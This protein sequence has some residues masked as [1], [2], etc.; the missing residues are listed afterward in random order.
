MPANLPRATLVGLSAILLWSTTIGLLRSVSEAF[1]PTGGAALIYSTTAVL[2]CLTRGVPN[3][4]NMPG[5]YLLTGGV[6]FVGYEICLA[7]AVGLARDRHQS[8]EMGMIN[9]LWPCLTI[10]LAIPFNQQ[11]FR[12][13]LWPG[14]LLS[15]SG[16]IWVM[17][18]ANGNVTGKMAQNIASNP[19]AY[20]LAFIAA[21]AWA[22]YNNITRRYARG[23]NG[24]TLFFMVTA[25]A[26]WLKFVLFTQHETL[27][28]SVT[29]AAE[30]L[31]M[32]AST[33]V[34]Y[35]AWNYGIQHGNLTLLATAS[36]F[37][38]VLSAL[39]AS[40]WL[41]LTP[42]ISFWQ[43]VAMITAGS[44]ICWLATRR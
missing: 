17:K 35:S 39:L 22:L 4:R 12:L 23:S 11:R 33:A 28:F 1:G 8:L 18:G 6:L 27:Q 37:T 19:T 44:L 42:P 7:L 38:P 5:R 30:V 13:W 10:V 40:L 32:G 15:L 20:L 9:Y 3:P 26:L 43:G 16:I 2:L 34:A 29:A 31:F 14:L 36:Y 25:L 21:I 24:V 41:G